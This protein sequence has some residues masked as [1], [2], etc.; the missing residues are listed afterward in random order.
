[1]APT[2]GVDFKLECLI[3]TSY[4]TNQKCKELPYST[5]CQQPA[6]CVQGQYED[7]SHIEVPLA[8]TSTSSIMANQGYEGI[9]TISLTT[10]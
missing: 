3:N 4:I 5:R 8:D 6:I 2:P 1:M 9:G 7:I 10:L